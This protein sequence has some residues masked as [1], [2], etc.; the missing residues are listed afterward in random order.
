M[1]QTPSNPIQMPTLILLATPEEAEQ[2]VPVV[3]NET[4]FVRVFSRLYGKAAARRVLGVVDQ[5]YISVMPDP[6]A[7]ERLFNVDWNFD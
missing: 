4:E 7:D 6:P 1:N 3:I 2:L 5:V